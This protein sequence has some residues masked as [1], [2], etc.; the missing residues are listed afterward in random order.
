MTFCPFIKCHEVSPGLKLFLIA[1]FV[2]RFEQFCI[3]CNEYVKYLH[4]ILTCD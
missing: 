3:S 2:L 1:A 4:A